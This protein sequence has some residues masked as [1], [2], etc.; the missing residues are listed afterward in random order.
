VASTDYSGELFISNEILK[1]VVESYRRVRN[2]LRFLLANTSDFDA[3][4]DALPLHE[5][6]EIDRYALAMT[7]KMQNAVASDYERYQ[8]QT[9]RRIP[10]VVLEPG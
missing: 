4:R 5:M 2:T 9:R 8:S 3:A 1:H 6:V 10:L 7:A